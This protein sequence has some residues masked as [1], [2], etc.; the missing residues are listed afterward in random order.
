MV[1]FDF[2]LIKSK[3]WNLK[4]KKVIFRKKFPFYELKIPLHTYGYYSDNWLITKLLII[5][6]FIYIYSD[7]YYIIISFVCKQVI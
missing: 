6:Y 2:N 5:I 1:G 7:V 3:N 4:L